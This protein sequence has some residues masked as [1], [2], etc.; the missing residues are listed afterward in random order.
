MIMGVLSALKSNKS[1]SPCQQT[2]RRNVK[3]EARVKIK[4]IYDS[5]FDNHYD[6]I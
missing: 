4:E 2:K 6:S 3:R 1:R 5:P